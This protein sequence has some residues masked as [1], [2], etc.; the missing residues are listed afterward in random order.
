MPVRAVHT[1]LYGQIAATIQQRIEQGQYPAGEKI[2]SESALV[3]EFG[4]SQTVVVQA[5]RLL[6]RDGWLVAEQGSGRRVRRAHAMVRNRGAGRAALGVEKS[7]GVRMLSVGIVPAP[8]RAAVAL[9]VDKDIPVW[10][11]TRL[12]SAGGEPLQL[13]TVYTL[14]DLAEGTQLAK[15]AALTVDPLAHLGAVKD[16]RFDY[17]CDRIGARKA[18]ADDA[19]VLAIARGDVVLTVLAIA[20]DITGTPVIAADAVMPATRMDLQDAFPLD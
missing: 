8:T 5:L 17:A 19:R 14:P 9:Q 10:A 6:V 2:P 16:V 20:Y 1:P 3:K 12:V 13:V 7:T 18:T 4:A 15:P 11:R